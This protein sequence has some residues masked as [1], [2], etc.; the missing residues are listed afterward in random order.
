MF[1]SIKIP[2]SNIAQADGKNNLG[3]EKRSAVFRCIFIRKPSIIKEED[4]GHKKAIKEDINMKKNSKRR[5]LS[6]LL[7]LFLMIQMTVQA[8][9]GTKESVDLASKDTGSSVEE[10]ERQREEQQSQ[11]D[12]LKEYQI[13]L[14]DELTELNN[15]LQEISNELA[16]TQDEIA[17]KNAEI[18]TAESRIAE[19]TTLSESQYES[20]K[21][22]VQYMYENGNQSYIELLLGASSFS[23]F[24]N[25]VEYAKS[26]YDYDRQ[27]LSDYQDTLAEL[28][29]QKEDLETA[30]EEL[31]AAEQTKQEQKSKADSLVAA[32]QEKLNTAKSDVADAQTEIAD[33]DAEIAR[34]KAYEE[35]LEAQKAKED[36]AR[37]EEIKRQE[38]E[39]IN[40]QQ[41]NNSDN[42]ANS[43]GT[44][45]GDN[46]GND[47]SGGGTKDDGASDNGTSGGGTVNASDVAMLAAL[48]QCEAGGESYEGKLAVGSVVMN[49]VDSSYFPDTVV[50]V[51]YQSGQFSPV[52]S[53]RFAVVL[54][55]G[56]DASCVQAAT[57]VLAGTRTLNCL[58]FRRNNGLING[59]VIGNHVF[60]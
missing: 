1:F 32:Q 21:K 50:G 48:I 9:T 2:S 58:Y 60:Y 4:K 7:I 23:D 17:A 56:A 20:M 24:L 3:I 41:G 28:K 47:T 27:E 51:I 52:A 18:E 42:N 40:G 5:M 33:T 45:S 44:S 39:L 16:D 35:E 53:G 14:S 8:D 57:E 54:S 59:T 34:Q 29:R 37:Q 46:A 43:D 6:A 10:L 13:N 26:I 55:S 12:S 15:G 31:L 19:L 22:R 38:E 36:A 30:K 25:R 11:L 49:R